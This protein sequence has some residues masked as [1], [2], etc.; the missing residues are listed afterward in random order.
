MI[1]YT[2]TNVV[3]YLMLTFGSPTT[4]VFDSPIEFVSTS[5]ESD[6]STYKSK[7]NKKLTIKSFKNDFETNLV[8]IT[9][10]GTYPFVLKTT[11]EKSY[12][13]YCWI[14]RVNINNDLF[15]NSGNKSIS[16]QLPCQPAHRC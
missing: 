3:T 15:I 5:N 6:F 14:N 7:D 11:S 10:N 13:I 9:K 8:V 1:I 4:I 12:Q 16:W 2:L